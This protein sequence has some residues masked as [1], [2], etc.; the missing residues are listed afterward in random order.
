MKSPLLNIPSEKET[1]FEFDISIQGVSSS[2]ASVRFMIEGQTHDSSINCVRSD[3]NDKWI[4]KI[5]AMSLT[6]NNSSFRIEVIAGGYYFCPTRG[7][8]NVI[9]Q[10][11]VKVTEYIQHNKPTEQA[12]IT[13]S[14]SSFSAP[15]A[16]PVLFETMSLTDRKNLQTRCQSAGQIFTKAGKVI[17]E[18]NVSSKHIV[19]ILEAVKKGIK[20]I[21][22]KL[23]K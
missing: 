19:D 14:S 6:E 15:K 22:T 10:P 23:Y 8:I 12:S 2:E 13:V 4:A 17:S 20:V 5:P 18:K 1:E 21:E 7:Q 16:V 3:R 11:S 9:S